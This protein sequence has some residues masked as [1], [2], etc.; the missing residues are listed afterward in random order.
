MQFW[1]ILEPTLVLYTQIVHLYCTLELY[2]HTVHLYYTLVLYSCMYTC[3]V[4]SYCT[5]VL[6]N[7][8]PGT[9]VS[10]EIDLKQKLVR[11]LGFFPSSF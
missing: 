9:S 4:Q 3:T 5:L 10:D 7:G 1:T 8:D 11:T 2:S 6:Y